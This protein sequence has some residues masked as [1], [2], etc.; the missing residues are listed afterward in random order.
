MAAWVYFTDERGCDS[1]V[2]DRAALAMMPF[3]DY[4]APS[5][6]FEKGA[7]KVARKFS[8]ASRRASSPAEIDSLAREALR[9]MRELAVEHGDGYYARQ[10]VEAL[11]K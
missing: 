4:I 8:K 10:Y 7:R 5:R 1:S 11:S 6:A 2:A 9:C 3:E